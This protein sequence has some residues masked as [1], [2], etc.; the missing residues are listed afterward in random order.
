MP[1]IGFMI[2]VERPA[3]RLLGS[4]ALGSV[5]LAAV[6]CS[7][8][9]SDD[10]GTSITVGDEVGDLDDSDSADLDEGPEI[11]CMPGQTRCAAANTLET[12][13][14]T[15]L[16]WDPSFCPTNASCMPCSEEDPECTGAVCV[17][18]CEL[19][20]ELPSSA[21][22]SF[23]GVGMVI[24]TTLNAEAVD[25]VVI[26]NPSETEVA[27]V[28]RY[29]IPLGSN[30]EEAVGEP[31]TLDPGETHVFLFDEGLT[32]NSN[33]GAGT[34]KYQSGGLY[35]FVSDLPV[36]AYQHT[37]YQQA[38]TN[39][40]SL[41]LPE[42]A[43]RQ[44]F[45]IMGYDPYAEPG[46]FTVIALENQTTVSWTPTA[47]TAGNN[48]PLPFV[49]IGEVGEY[50]INR[51][52]VMRIAASANGEVPEFDQDVS[53]TVVTSDK[54][55]LVMA[56]VVGI[57]VPYCTDCPPA[58]D[59]VQEQV[60]PLDY[61]GDKYVCAHSPVRADE[62]HYW[63]VFAG[64][65]DIDVTASPPVPG[66]PFHFD[67]RGDYVEFSVPNGT[68]FI[69]EGSG[70]FMPVQYTANNG[71]SGGLG[72]PAMYQMIPTAQFLS[73]YLFVTPADYDQDYVQV[74]RAIGNA[75]VY[76]DGVEVGGYTDTGDHQVATVAIVAG[77]HDIRSEEPFGIL[78]VGYKGKHLDLDPAIFPAAYGYP[79]G[80]KVEQIFIP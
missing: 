18:P 30:I 78:Q 37:P 47:A 36:I 49:E 42:D 26:G 4:V 15:G 72:D 41:L 1:V 75:A 39:E 31:E 34:S 63:R 54:P 65:G 11:I 64:S 7:G 79:G 28:Q 14:P 25:A 2:G 8:S 73:R 71:L 17:G 57:R 27:T 76:L 56:G 40:S 74:I 44:D 5:A 43:A 3:L 60:I 10:T 19:G 48:L 66:S 35:H 21:G 16:A 77:S 33:N 6:A 62:D 67:A 58:T 24:N 68:D 22:C 53:G 9:G 32:E 51:F 23:F 29:L 80:M 69:L 46:Y 61:W 70:A 50:T 38:S 20:E 52:D 55:I 13:A 12:C 45:V 59:H